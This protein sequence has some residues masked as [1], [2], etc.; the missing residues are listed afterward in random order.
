MITRRRFLGHAGAVSLAGL[1]A[2]LGPSRQVQA[3]D[4]KALLVVFLQGGYDG[5]NLLVPL[6]GAYSEY[7]KARPGL[8][9]PTSR[10]AALPATHLD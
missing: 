4:Y 6:D 5:N 7:S 9:L 8:A 2:A 1:A 3:A 10:L